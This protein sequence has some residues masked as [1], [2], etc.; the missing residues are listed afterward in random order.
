MSK[1][2]KS[3]LILIICSLIM[4][5][6]LFYNV[7]NYYI[8]QSYDKNLI[9]TITNTNIKGT[10]LKIDKSKLTNIN[11]YPLKNGKTLTFRN[12]TL[13]G[14]ENLKEIS[15]FKFFGLEKANAT[16]LHKV[17]TLKIKSVSGNNYYV[18]D[19]KLNLKDNKTITTIE[20]SH[21]KS[22][23]LKLLNKKPDKEITISDNLSGL[24]KDSIIELSDS[25][26]ISNIENAKEQFI[27]YNVENNGFYKYDD[28]NIRLDKSLF[29]T[30]KKLIILVIII[31][32][33]A[34]LFAFGFISS[35]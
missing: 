22:D 12:D 4:M 1:I 30:I 32:Y 19:I 23:V 3:K 8:L 20:L 29:E 2:K 5:S 27:D 28:V 9:P 6:T 15:N 25:D 31:D 33:A 24:K 35:K 13:T 34:L 10:Y 11:N 16:K 14:S 26:K 21:I 17:Q 7:V 18:T